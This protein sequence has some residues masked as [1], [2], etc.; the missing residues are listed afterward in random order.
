MRLSTVMEIFQFYFG[1]ILFVGFKTDC[2]PLHYD[3]FGRAIELK[4]NGACTI[5]VMSL[6]SITQ[7]LECHRMNT[8]HIPGKHNKLF[9][10]G[11]IL[12]K[13]LF[14]QELTPAMFCHHT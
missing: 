11:R 6:Y 7:T 13:T 8:L 5:T 3:S 4:K 10:R 2:L 14:L 9:G 12:V 1:F